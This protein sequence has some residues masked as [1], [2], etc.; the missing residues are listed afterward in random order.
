MAGRGQ[1]ITQGASWLARQ[2]GIGAAR[3]TARTAGTV[4]VFAAADQALTGGAGRRAIGSLVSTFN[5][6]SDLIG[7]LPTVGLAAAGLGVLGGLYNTITGDGPSFLNMA[8]TIGGLAL[9]ASAL[10]DP[11]TRQTLMTRIGL[12][13][14]DPAPTA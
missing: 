14:S 9:G 4:G 6:A 7:T 8:L 13:A 1:I 11:E 10:A 5:D 3:T 2:F 12:G